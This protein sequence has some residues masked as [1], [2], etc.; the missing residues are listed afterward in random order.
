MRTPTSTLLRVLALAVTLPAVSA[1]LRAQGAAPVVARLQGR[2]FDSVAMRPIP[3]A[4]IRIVRADNPAIGRTAASDITGEFHYDS[5]TAGTWLAT[6]LHPVLDSLRVEPGIIRIDITEPGVVEVPLTTP[7][8]RTMIA[9]SCRAPMA[10]DLGT[11]VGEVRQVSDDAPLVG[12]AVHVEWPEW[13]LQRG[14]L[15]T[16]LRRMVARTDSAGR[17]AMC[18]VPTGTTL[19]AFAWSAGD[20][21]GAIE[22]PVTEA[23]YTVQDFHVGSVERLTVL[24]DSAGTPV[25]ASGR[26]P[27][28]PPGA[29]APLTTTV[30]R[31]RAVVRGQVRTLA[32]QPVVNAVVRVIGSG[33]QVRTNDSGAFAVADAASGTQ[34][35][36]ARAIGHN[37]ERQAVTLREG[38][39][40]TVTLRLSVRRVELDTVRVVAGK[41]LAPEVRAIERRMRAG[42]GVILNA[43]TVKERATVFV[44]DALRGINGVSVAGV[45]GSGQMIMMRSP[46]NGAE[47]AANIVVDGLKVQTSGNGEFVLDDYVKRDNVAAIEVYPRSNLVPPEF[48]TVSGG[49]GVVVVWTK[50]ATGGVVPVPPSPSR[51]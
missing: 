16:D 20:T 49:C 18:G 12:A 13:V 9:L 7:S 44:S 17:Y 40:V 35:V 43:N 42:V 19:R 51:P 28:G 33:T 26:T 2:V 47:C 31:G 45:G 50:Q 1:T 24:L 5:V 46:F 32:G 11:V 22:L 4:T 21:T 27:P 25:P 38:E 23:G 39:P 48:L 30:R 3:R 10:A 41:T 14:R 36:E 15:V 37:P 6:F 8:V 29:P 34:T